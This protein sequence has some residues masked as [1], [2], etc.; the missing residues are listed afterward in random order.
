[1]KACNTTFEAEDKILSLVP[2]IV[3]N[4]IFLPFFV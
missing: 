1:M 2:F 3:I 4:I